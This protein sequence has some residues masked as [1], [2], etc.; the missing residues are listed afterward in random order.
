MPVS[1]YTPR[2]VTAFMVDRIDPKPGETLFDPGLRHWRFSDLFADQATCESAYV[3]HARRRGADAGRA[4]RRREE[5]AA[6]T[7]SA[8]PTCCCTAS[9][10]RALCATTTRWP[11]RY[12]SYT[13]SE[14]VDI[15][16]TNPPFGGREEDGIE[17]QLPAPFP[18]A[19]DG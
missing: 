7:C 9:R 6:R 4:A 5:A 18:H 16:V 17:K 19:G 2:A 12:I 14:R 3:K 11:G 13:Q 1:I 15:V 8:S 10:T